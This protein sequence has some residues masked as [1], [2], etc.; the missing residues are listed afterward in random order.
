[1]TNPNSSKRIDWRIA[2][3]GGH[4]QR[5]TGAPADTVVVTPIGGA[6]IDLSGA[7]LPARTTLTKVS[8][9]GGVKLRVPAGVDVEV[10][11]FHL[12][13]GRRVQPAA[14]SPSAPVVRVRAY[15]IVGGVEVSRA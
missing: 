12:L 15:G 14:P 6:D 11:G 8:L 13:G 9:L 7:E 3:L 10:K 2:L 5:I 1:M 4:K